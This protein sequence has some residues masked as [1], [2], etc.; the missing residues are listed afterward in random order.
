MQG[1]VT[2]VKPSMKYRE[3]YL[4]FYADWIDSGEDMVPWVI[5]KDPA[6]F[7]AMI[8]FLYAEDCEEKINDSSW[9]PHSTYW[10]LDDQNNVVGAVNIRHRL[11]ENLFYRGGHIGYGIRPSA[12]RKGYA[13]LLLAGALEKTREL[14]ISRALVVCDNGNLGSERTIIRN[15]GVFESEFIEDDGNIV[16]R[17]WIEL[18]MRNAADAFRR[19]I[20]FLHDSSRIEEINKGYSTD[21]KYTAYIGDQ[22]YVLRVFDRKQYKAKKAEFDILLMMADKH[23]KCSRPIEIGELYEDEL[24]YMLLYLYP[25]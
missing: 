11:N 9:V 16:K 1:A 4:S 6:D 18:Q 20:P 13:T 25:W 5:E 3:A 7:Q 19:T 14:G 12:R 21:R 8:E 24:G 17:F 2:L 15:G 10:L 22:K 23:V